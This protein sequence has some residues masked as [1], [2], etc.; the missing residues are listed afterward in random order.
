ML[1]RIADSLFWLNRYMERA[2]SLLRVASTH[3]I[4][5]LD[6]D[7]NGSLTWKPVL[8]M[9]T[10]LPPELIANIEHDTI[11]SLKKLLTDPDNSNSLRNLV[12]RARENARGVQDHITKEVWE[13]VN[14]MYHLMNQQTLNKMLQ[15][16]EVVEVL[17]LFI[18]H[19]VQYTGVTDI[20]MSRGSG[21]IF[22]NLGK[23]IERS[24]STI[25]LTRKQYEQIGYCIDDPQDIMHWRYLLQPLSGYETHL[26]Q[27]RTA[28]YNYNVLHQVLFNEEFPH[29][30]VYSLG[31][32]DRHLEETFK[33]NPR[34]EENA[35]LMRCFGRLDSKVRYTDLE[36]LNNDNLQP[37]LNGLRSDLLSFIGQFSQHFFSYS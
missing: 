30:M 4:L 19:C 35:A 12:G 17:E 28:N 16:Y 11:A 37:Y 27:Y 8:E 29:S 15:S 34:S 6:K 2:D 20:T 23:Y 14:A 18:K 31:R 7:V 21:W 10:A 36:T 22:M 32:V 9:Y 3:Y 25:T 24:L 1:S 33:R 26:K 13:E 5:S